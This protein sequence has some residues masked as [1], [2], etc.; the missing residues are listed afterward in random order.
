[1][2]V[3][4]SLNRVAPLE[5]CFLGLDVGGTETRWALVT[6]SGSLIGEG[7]AGARSEAHSP[8]EAARLAAL[9]VNDAVRHAQAQRRLSGLYVGMTGVGLEAARVR[10]KL[11]ALYALD[12]A[13][14]SV[15][16]DAELMFRAVLAPG[17]GYLIYAGTGS[18]AAFVDSAGQFHRAGGRG[19]L[20]DDAGGGYWI[21]REALRRIWR[22]EDQSPGAWRDSP[23]A[24]AVL[25]AVGGSASIFSSRYLR[26]TGRGAVGLL[27]LN[28]AEHAHHDALAQEILADA[29]VELARLANAMLRRYG[30][31]RLVVT[32]RA[33]TL[34]PMIETA[35]RAAMPLAAAVEF[36]RVQA[37]VAAARMAAEF[38][39]PSEQ[40]SLASIGVSL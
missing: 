24:C 26:D 23:M 8:P 16:S 19:V 35:M 32:G 2:K 40:N 27:A 20:L 13:A 9:A 3:E 21:A 30:P 14:V 31:R 29:G 5:P 39:V 6:A 34:H 1:M 33:A 36:E 12:V 17:E 25:A 4:H 28:V 22:R 15:E 38:S 18:I 11:A 10:E 7:I 37:H